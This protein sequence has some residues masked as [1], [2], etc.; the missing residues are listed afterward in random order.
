MTPRPVA[1]EALNGCRVLVSRCPH[2]TIPSDATSRHPQTTITGRAAREWWRATLFASE[3]EGRWPL[4]HRDSSDFQ[5]A[6]K[7]AA[8]LGADLLREVPLI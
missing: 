1:F 3:R 6:L 4:G 7:Q 2:V 8:A 5:G